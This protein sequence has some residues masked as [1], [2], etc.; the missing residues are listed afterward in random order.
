[1]PRT[2]LRPEEEWARSLMTKE[3]GVQVEAH[4]DNSRP[5]MHDLRI[6]YADR[7]QEREQILRALDDPPEGLAEL[8]GVLVRE[9]DWRAREGLV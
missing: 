6:A 2:A 1:M 7:E 5:G 8:R 4:D 3:L 9:H